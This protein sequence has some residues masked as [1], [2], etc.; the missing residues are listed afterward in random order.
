TTS[1]SSSIGTNIKKGLSNS[2]QKLS[3]IQRFIFS[4]TSTII[5]Y[6]FIPYI[7]IPCFST[8]YQWKCKMKF[9][10]LIL[11][12]PFRYSPLFFSNHKLNLY[13][14]SPFKKFKKE[15]YSI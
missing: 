9:M 2:F 12:S 11:L 13:N 14:K 4:H 8:F 1:D 10:I 15:L 6:P 7:F 3:S 5:F